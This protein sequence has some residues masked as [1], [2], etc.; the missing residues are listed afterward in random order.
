MNK[1]TRIL[2]GL[3][4]FLALTVQAGDWPQF[5]RTDSR[6]GCDLTEQVALPSRLCCWFDL[7]SPILAS[8]AIVDGKAY[9]IS[10]R[11]LLVRLDLASN[12]VDWQLALGGVNNECSPAVANGKV[13]VGTTAGKFYVVDAKTGRI[14][15]TQD[16]G[17][18]V[19]AAP[20]LTGD[21]VYYGSM[22]GLFRA[23][24]LEGNEKWIY[25]ASNYVLHSAA[26]AGG[27][28]VFSDGNSRLYWMKD[29]GA[30]CEVV[31]SYHYDPGHSGEFFSSLMIWNNG[32]YAGM[33]DQE[34]GYGRRLARFDCTTGKFDR[35]LIQNVLVHS[36]VSVDTGN[37]MIFIGTAYSGFYGKGQGTN[38]ARQW[39]TF[40]GNAANTANL[41]RGVNSAPAVVGNCVIFGSEKGEVLFCQKE[42]GKRLWSYQ[43]ASRKS[44]D[45]PIAVSN[46]KVLAGCWDGRLY[47]FWDGTEVTRPVVVDAKSSP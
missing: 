27:Q 21:R 41:A 35:D 7:G 14:L 19:F 28:I 22:N 25:T 33:V 31:R 20:L 26:A 36:C 39:S 2:G 32:V 17:A 46:G 1:S 4:L 29:T 15:K 30:A 23:L 9:V 24:D 18:G 43:A 47:G 34:N 40:D 42:T 5:K 44:F 37:P 45:A 10:G 11:G 6:Q 38:S 16:A 3:L 8:P 12:K 13:F